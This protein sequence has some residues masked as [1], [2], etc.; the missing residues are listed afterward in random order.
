MTQLPP[1]TKVGL[2]AL[3]E[4]ERFTL[5]GPHLPPV[6]ARGLYSFRAGELDF[7]FIYSPGSESRLF[8]LFSGYADRSR[9]TPPVFHRWSWATVFPGHCLYIADPCLHL[10]PTL[11]IA[12]YAGT[13]GQPAIPTIGQLVRNVATQI[14]VPLAQT[15]GYGSSGGGFAALQLAL[16]LPEIISVVINPQTEVTKF[17][18][19]AVDRFLRIC[20]GERSRSSALEAFHP[21]LSLIPHAL[22]LMKR[23]IVYAQNTL[24]SHHL[25]EHFRPLMESMG[26]AWDTEVKTPTL[27]TIFFKHN[28]GHVA[29]EP[30]TLFPTLIERALSFAVSEQEP[31]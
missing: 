28:G 4:L 7:D 26:S 5:N 12:W 8:V 2:E 11:S 6:M 20:M 29:A 10:D 9:L 14:D 31:A 1:P 16:E 27:Q 19:G 15:I 21:R 17:D 30:R 24:D 13:R 18:N 25:N 23:R 22:H 3:G